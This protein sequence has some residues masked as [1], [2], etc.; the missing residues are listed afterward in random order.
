MKKV[1]ICAVLGITLGMG[2]NITVYAA[3]TFQNCGETVTMGTDKGETFTVDYSADQIA[4]YTENQFEEEEVT[5]LCE[6]SKYTFLWNK[7]TFKYKLH[8]PDN[9]FL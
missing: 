3:G 6:P 9:G 2:S 1:I 8:I 4:E 5:I 7:D